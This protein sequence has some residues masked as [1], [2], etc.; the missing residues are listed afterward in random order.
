MRIAI[1]SAHYPPNFIS[2]GTLVPQRIAETLAARG[3]DVHVFAG[4]LESGEPDLIASTEHDPHGVTVHWTTVTGFIG[5]QERRNYDNAAMQAEFLD[6]LQRVRPDVVHVHALQGMG[7]SLLPV[8]RA[9]GAATIVTMHDM[10]WWCARQ[11]LVTRQMQPCT[12]VVDCG[13]CPCE[14]D[15]PWLVERNRVLLSALRAVDL[16]LAPSSSMLD[17]LAANGIATERLALDENPSPESVR[18]AAARRES[19]VGVRFVFA[20]GAHPLKGGQLAVAAAELLRDLTGW[21]LDLYGYHAADNAALGSGAPGTGVTV[22][23]DMDNVRSLPPYDPSTTAELLAGYDVLVL[24]SIM[25]ESYS[26][27]TREALAA[28]CVVITG[29]NPGPREVV[30]EDVNGLVVPRGDAVALADAMRSLVTDPELL[31][32][33][34]PAPG[35]LTL[36]SLAD[37]VDGLEEHYHRL[38]TRPAGGAVTAPVRPPIRRVLLASGIGSAPLRYRGQLPAEA[39]AS[40]GIH[41]DVHMYRDVQV[42]VKARTTDALVLYRVP[43]TEQVLD[44]ISMVRARPEPVPVLFDI[45]D[46]VFDPGLAPELDPILRKVDGLDLDLYWQGVRRYRTTMEAADG[47]IGSTRM[48]CETVERLTGL[49]TYRFENGVSRQIARISEYELARPRADG[50]I[51]I[52]YFSGTNTHNE[53]WGFVEPAVVELLRRRPEAELWIGGLLETSA[54][55]APFAHRIRRFPLLPW[56]ELPGLLRDVDIN[57]APL[58]PNTAFNDAKSAIKWLEAA[59]VATPTVATASEPFREAVQDGHT[60]LLV[61]SLDEWLEA[62]CR[63]V[64]EPDLRIRLGRHAREQVL[65]TLSPGAQGH[66]YRSLLE[67]ARD[68]VARDGHRELFTDWTPEYL[69]EAWGLWAPDHYGPVDIGPLGAVSPGSDGARNLARVARD[70]RVNALSHLRTEGA[71]P[72]VRKAA[73]VLLRL[74]TRAARRIRP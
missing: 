21:T 23:A 72:T 60:G 30:R 10:W 19:A 33:L 50:P 52:G 38:T 14:V 2:G 9:S 51:R 5:W 56:T 42:P 54:M 69:S 71:G 70:Y 26:L 34:R 40:V 68:R 73:S 74:P 46:L 11:F 28:G 25:L 31:A 59:L 65:I 27:L 1:V 63:L 67:R 22:P 39:L 44:V 45:D 4:A 18:S 66:R 15:N 43:A 3:H 55:L 16:V 32:R 24:S 49:P 64:D 20:G 29:D 13:L 35:T 62:M 7:G 53:D 61:D 8:A 6:F 57:L 37:Q 47:Y 12:S 48:L 58:V 36:R 41:M 17:L